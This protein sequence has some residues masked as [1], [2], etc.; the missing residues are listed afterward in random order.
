VNCRR[1]PSDAFYPHK[2]IVHY[3]REA[4]FGIPTKAPKLIDPRNA[5]AIVTSP[6]LAGNGN[7]DGRLE[8]RAYEISIFEN[9]SRTPTS[10]VEGLEICV[11]F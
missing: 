11:S 3:L 9:G 6:V 10:N 7:A 4:M 8:L 5:M 2:K 1:K